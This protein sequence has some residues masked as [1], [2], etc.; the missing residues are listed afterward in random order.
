MRLAAVIIMSL[1]VIIIV[2]APLSHLSILSLFLLT[3]FKADGHPPRAQF[4]LMLLPIKAEFFFAAATAMC[5]LI[6]DCW[7]SLN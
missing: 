7:V 5:S 1:T 3:P 6:G 4:F 2:I